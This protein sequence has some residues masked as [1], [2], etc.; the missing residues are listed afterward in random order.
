[1]ELICITCPKGCTMHVEVHNG[2][3]LS[4]RGNSCP[5]GREYAEHEVLYP[6]RMVTSTVKVNHGTIARCPV[7]TSVP[8]P[9]EIIFD[10]MK[11]IEQVEL[12]APV[13]LH[14]VILDSVCGLNVQ[15]IATRTIRKL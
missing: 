2:Q 1:M 5:K 11:E 14:D 3:I 9:K 6:M 10:V 4:V 8:V 13:Y 7:M 15:L 12:E